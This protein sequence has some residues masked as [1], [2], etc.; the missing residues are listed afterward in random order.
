MFDIITGFVCGFSWI[1][2]YEW[3]AP[4]AAIADAGEN[5][6]WV[7]SGNGESTNPLRSTNRAALFEDE[8]E[9]DEFGEL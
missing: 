5:S 2:L 4:A 3:P 8:P 1:G 6:D 7:A 9:V